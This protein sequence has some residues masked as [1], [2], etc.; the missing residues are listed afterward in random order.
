MMARVTC[1]AIVLVIVLGFFS[2]SPVAWAQN[3][4][5]SLS[6]S[7]SS[8]TDATLGTNY[9]TELDQA[10]SALTDLKAARQGQAE[11]RQLS[12]AKAYGEKALAVRARVLATVTTRL[13]EGGCP[14]AQQA[15]ISTSLAT[16]QQTI[17]AAQ[18]SLSNATTSSVAREIIKNAIEDTHVFAIFS[19]ASSGLCVSAR[20]G[21]FLDGKLAASLTKISAAGVDT[22]AVEAQVV[23]VKTDLTVVEDVFAALVKTP[24]ISLTQGRAQL[25]DA[26]AKLATIK[27]ALTELKTSLESLLTSYENSSASTAN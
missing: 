5:S 1:K 13:R 22:T 12:A 18:T 24:G 19:P 23:E 8:A 17:T 2:V 9:K 14:D 6:N 25:T 15:M 27:T 7:T 21:E 11:A 16:A 20:I 26:R 10:R 4:S 3:D